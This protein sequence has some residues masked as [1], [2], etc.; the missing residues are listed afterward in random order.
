M[1]DDRPVFAGDELF[2]LELAVADDA[3]GD[4][5]HATGRARARQLSPQ[6]RRQVEA[7]KIVEG[8]ARPVGVDEGL[9]DLARIAHRLL[10][11]V[12][13]H[14][15]EHN[16]IDPLVLEQL[17][18]LEN[19]VDVP[20]DGLAFTVR[21]GRQDHAV[22]GLHG[23]A[24]VAH[25]FGGFR[26]DFPAHG[27]IV[28]RVDRAVLRGEIPHMAERGIDVVVLAEIFVDGLRLGWRLDDHDFHSGNFLWAPA[29]QPQSPLAVR[30]RDMETPR[31]PVK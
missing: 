8:A 5:L 10:D 23:A 31:P 2:D 26:V 1:G 25:P 24:D 9:V 13:G 11:R 20:G 30:R 22:G 28:V 6:N 18:T 12:L 19:L 4:R 29:T 17:L 27:E 15:V 3:Q 21:V 16:A 14:R 7:D